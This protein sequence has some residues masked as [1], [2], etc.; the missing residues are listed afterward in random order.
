M[1]PTPAK[2]RLYAGRGEGSTELNAFD[3][4]LLDAGLGNTNLLQ[5]TSI[6]PPQ[7]WLDE[8]LDIPAGSLVPTAYGAVSSAN[9]GE[10]VSAAIGVGRNRHS[11]GVIMEYSGR[12]HQD[13]AEEQVR[14]MVREAFARRDLY[15]EEVLVRSVEH[16]VE[17]VGCAFAA[18]ALW[19]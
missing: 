4:A 18:V 16:R 9:A 7:A 10:T 12:C 8:D 17:R 1:L 2:F 11:F 15:L 19:Y 14:A 5:V 6:L 13:Q 3:Q